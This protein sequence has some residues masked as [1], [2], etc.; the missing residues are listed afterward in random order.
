MQSPTGSHTHLLQCLLSWHVL[1]GIA[2]HID[3]QRCARYPCWPWLE[4]Q[5]GSA[6]GC[7]AVSAAALAAAAAAKGCEGQWVGPGGTQCFQSIMACRHCTA[8]R[9]VLSATRQ[10]C[11]YRSV[12][13]AAATNKQLLV[14]GDINYTIQAAQH[15][16]PPLQYSNLGRY[17][18]C[19]LEPQTSKHVPRAP[20]A[21]LATSTFCPQLVQRLLL[22]SQQG[23]QMWV[24][25]S[26][27]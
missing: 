20:K 21:Y 13:A 10:A 27:P 5:R 26:A 17:A 25:R 15:V 7:T 1:R 14:H 16:L 19:A 23:K 24:R 11:M 8:T 9:A 6:A 12:P 22:L 4:A 2:Q 18:R 3:M